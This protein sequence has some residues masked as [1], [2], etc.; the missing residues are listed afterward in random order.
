MQ[1]GFSFD[2]DAVKRMVDELEE[3][4]FGLKFHWP[5]T[6]HSINSVAKARFNI[7]SRESTHW[8]SGL[9]QAELELE[10]QNIAIAENIHAIRKAMRALQLKGIELQERLDNNDS[11]ARLELDLEQFRDDLELTQFRLVD[12]FVKLRDAH[13]EKNVAQEQ[14]NRIVAEHQSELEGQSF[15]ELQES[16]SLPALHEQQARHVAGLIWSAASNLPSDVGTALSELPQGDGPMEVQGV[17][18]RQMEIQGDTRLTSEAISLARQLQTLS[19]QQLNRVMSLSATARSL[20]LD[21]ETAPQQA[22]E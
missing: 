17:L 11:P 14:L 2:F 1:A 18:Q 15:M 19:P 22:T 5:L 8:F 6:N 20:N 12:F 21:K 10:G 4:P 9:R 16:L 7:L 13:M 3:T